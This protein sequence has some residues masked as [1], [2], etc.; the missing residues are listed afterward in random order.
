MS[1]ITTFAPWRK[2]SMAVSRP[3]P[4]PAPVMIA[5]LFLKRIVMEVIF[6]AIWRGASENVP[7]L[8]WLW[9]YFF[10]FVKKIAQGKFLFH[11]IDKK[12]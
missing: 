11:K 2:N 1:A 10:P 5:V 7:S 8:S 6:S 4:L 3:I 12:M 9:T